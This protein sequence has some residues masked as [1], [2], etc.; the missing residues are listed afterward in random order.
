MKSRPDSTDLR[1]SLS[2]SLGA[3]Y[4]IDREL[5]VEGTSRIFV[6]RE[7][8]ENRDVAIIVLDEGLTEGVG[9]DVF[10]AELRKARSF[11]EAHTLPVL[12]A[13][14]TA[15]RL[16]YYSV[17]MVRGTSLRQ[18]IEQGPLGF[19]ES[20]AVLRDVARSM[21]YAHGQGFLHRTL[22]PEHIL[23]AKHTSVVTGFGLARALERA[24]ATNPDALLT[25]LSFTSLPYIAPEQARATLP[26]RRPISTRGA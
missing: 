26:E 5:D 1:A 12:A 20:V 3:A 21:L 10:L 16:F 22:S 14:R 8:S 19:D 24:G 11:E 15:E 6:A 7:E 23:L 25:H 18:R 13:G 2:L 17:P 9:A 4:V